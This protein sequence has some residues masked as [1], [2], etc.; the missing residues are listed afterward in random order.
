MKRHDIPFENPFVPDYMSQLTIETLPLDTAYYIDPG[1]KDDYEPPAIFIGEARRLVMSRQVTIDDED[2]NPPSPLELIGVMR[3]VYVDP[4]HGPKTAYVA[5]TRF[6]QPYSLSDF[7]RLSMSGSDQEEFM[8]W[9]EHLRDVIHFSGFL[10]LQPKAHIKRN[11]TMPPAEIYGSPAL[12]PALDQL[13]KKG[14]RRIK[15]YMKLHASPSVVPAFP[16]APT[17]VADTEKTAE[18]SENK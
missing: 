13:R 17:P 2:R 7:D 10:A 3:T 4:E 12:Y 18:K 15:A 16:A 6:M 1:D 9:A 14:D 5:D 8:A 11:G